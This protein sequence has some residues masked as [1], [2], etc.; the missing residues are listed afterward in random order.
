[1][2]LPCLR[3]RKDGDGG[4]LGSPSEDHVSCAQKGDAECRFLNS[5]HVALGPGALRMSYGGPFLHQCDGR[6][7]IPWSLGECAA[8]P[9]CHSRELGFGVS[10]CRGLPQKLGGGCGAVGRLFAFSGEGTRF[11]NR[12]R[13]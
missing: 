13:T 3:T 6:Q 7:G 10:I 9:L 12:F 4:Y 5:S 11:E 2:A 8:S 1:M